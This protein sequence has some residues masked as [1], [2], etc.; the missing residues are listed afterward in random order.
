MHCVVHS[1]F[2]LLVAALA[3]KLTNNKFNVNFV[4]FLFVSIGVCTA[5]CR[6]LGM[7][8]LNVRYIQVAHRARPC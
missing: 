4:F 8:L 1:F 7:P 6:G 5:V 3:S 2:F